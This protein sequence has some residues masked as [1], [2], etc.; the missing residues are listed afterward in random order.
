MA[1]EA[2]IETGKGGAGRIDGARPSDGSGFG[3]EKGPEIPSTINTKEELQK[4]PEEIRRVIEGFIPSEEEINRERER[5]E[6]EVERQRFSDYINGVA[7]PEGSPTEGKDLKSSF[8]SKTREFF[9]KNSKRLKIWLRFK[10]KIGVKYSKTITHEEWMA[11]RAEPGYFI[12]NYEYGFI[13]NPKIS[14]KSPHDGTDYLMDPK[15]TGHILVRRG[16]PIGVGSQFKVIV[17]IR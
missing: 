12:Y 13:R 6:R 14:I 17:E 4:L 10:F 8:W 16:L 9:L 15:G 3:G 2:E 11:V 7:P 1:E 5:W